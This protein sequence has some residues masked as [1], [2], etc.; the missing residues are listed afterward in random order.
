M[1]TTTEEDVKPFTRVKLYPTSENY[2]QQIIETNISMTGSK[3][4]KKERTLNAPVSDFVHAVEDWAE[5]VKTAATI[6]DYIDSQQQLTEVKCNVIAPGLAVMP[7][8]EYILTEH[9]KQMKALKWFQSLNTI[10]R[11]WA[12]KLGGDLDRMKTDYNYI[13]E[14]MGKVGDYRDKAAKACAFCYV[15]KEPLTA[16]TNAQCQAQGFPIRYTDASVHI[17]LPGEELRAW[18][19]GITIDAKRGSFDNFEAYLH[20]TAWAF[21]GGSWSSTNVEHIKLVAQALQIGAFLVENVLSRYIGKAVD[22][23]FDLAFDF[24]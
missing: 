5:K 14:I 17:F 8:T 12:V 9:F 2:G 4:L 10:R 23:D 24:A 11:E 16:C 20:C 3:T 13:Q 6:G 15:Q 19:G 7:V 22:D 21:R 18:G 1:A